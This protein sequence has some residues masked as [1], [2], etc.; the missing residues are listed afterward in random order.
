MKKGDKYLF[1]AN[2]DEVNRAK[3]KYPIDMMLFTLNPTG[4][5]VYEDIPYP[6][7]SFIDG[8]YRPDI[9]RSAGIGDSDDNFTRL[10]KLAT[11]PLMRENFEIHVA[12]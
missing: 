1:C 3:R 5:S 10:C 6:F 12:K 9:I 4:M 7:S 2:G 11:I 8:T